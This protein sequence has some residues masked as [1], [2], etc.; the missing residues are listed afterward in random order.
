MLELVK[1]TRECRGGRSQCSGSGVSDYI[2]CEIVYVITSRSQ[3][4]SRG[5]GRGRG[6]RRETG[7]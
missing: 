5:A 3:S 7:G 1:G 2:T 6:E 4:R